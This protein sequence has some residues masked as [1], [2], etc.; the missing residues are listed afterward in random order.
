V[1]AGAVPTLAELGLP[2]D[3][4]PELERGSGLVLIAGTFEAE[5]RAAAMMALAEHL[6]RTR[7][8]H[9]VTLEHSIEWE[10]PHG[11][12]LI[13]QREI[14]ADVDDTPEA[15]ARAVDRA[16]RLPAEVLAVTEVSE[17]AIIDRILAAAQ[18]SLLAL[19]TVP[20]SKPS[21]AVDWLARISGPD[22]REAILSRAADCLRAIVMAS[23]S[24][25]QVHRISDQMR[26]L[27]RFA[28]LD[29]LDDVKS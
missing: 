12:C 20:G 17:H 19:V 14:G 21:H 22:H 6:S 2:G 10:L 7:S 5:T 11:S 3:L 25:P 1:S 15:I 29:A 27:I 26:N 23:E 8:G 9:L 13:T 18:S 28:Q 16:M 24:A 4:G